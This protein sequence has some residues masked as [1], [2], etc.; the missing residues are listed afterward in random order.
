MTSR[1]DL[2]CRAERLTVIGN[3]EKGSA[4][5]ERGWQRVKMASLMGSSPPYGVSRGQVRS[6]PEWSPNM[7]RH[8]CTVFHAH[9]L[10]R[11]ALFPNLLAPT[12][13]RWLSYGPFLVSS[14]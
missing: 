3:D 2:I 10:V 1:G 5:A 13:L 6:S 12:V 8:V 4:R 11:Y 9:S 14:D 7:N